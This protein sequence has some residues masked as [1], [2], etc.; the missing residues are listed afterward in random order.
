MLLFFF[1]ILLLLPII[2]LLGV[3]S[4]FESI[5]IPS[6]IVPSLLIFS[7]I[8]SMINIPVYTYLRNDRQIEYYYFSQEWSHRK[9]RVYINLGGCVIPISVSI[10]IVLSQFSPKILL[11]VVVTALVVALVSKKFARVVPRLGITMPMFIPPMVTALTAVI[12]G[13]ILDIE[14]GIFIASYAGGVIGVILGADVLNLRK[15][16]QMGAP[17]VA[18][19]GAGTFD[20]IF[21]TG[22][23]SVMLV[24][25]IY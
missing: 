8:G 15:V 7:L 16:M 23:L 10:Y 14:Q 1:M 20:G 9:S 22:I 21:L 5:G 18:I 19:G 25:F 6:Y 11:S 2:F 3:G 17:K 4:A 13:L 24:A 12:I